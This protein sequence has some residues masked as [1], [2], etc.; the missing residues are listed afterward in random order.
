[1][2]MDNYNLYGYLLIYIDTYNLKVMEIDDYGLH[3]S[4]LIV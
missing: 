1:M 3:G 2:F 4:F